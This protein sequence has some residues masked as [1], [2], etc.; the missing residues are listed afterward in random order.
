MFRLDVD[1]CQPL[2][3]FHRVTDIVSCPTIH[4]YEMERL[5]IED[6]DFIKGLLQDVA[7]ST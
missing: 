1:W 6:V 3:F 5:G 2:K 7:K 4:M